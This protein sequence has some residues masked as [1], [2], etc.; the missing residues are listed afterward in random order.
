[1]NK[2]SGEEGT[3][4]LIPTSTKKTACAPNNQVHP[5]HDVA[6]GEAGP[7]H[8]HLLLALES[9]LSEVFAWQGDPP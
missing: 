5:R 7:S 4:L 2:R 9:N 6:D 8:W 3:N 1:M